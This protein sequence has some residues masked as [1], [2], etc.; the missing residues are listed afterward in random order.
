M[1]LSETGQ[2]YTRVRRRNREVTD[3]S[4]IRGFLR[5]APM[6][7]V[8]TVHEGQPFLNS[9]LFLYDEDAHVLYFHSA[10]EGRTRSNIEANGRV[11]VSIA[12]MGRMLT[13]EKVTDY[14]VEY[15]SVTVFG[16]ARVVADPEEVRSVLERQ[17][18]KYFPHRR[19]GVDYE[20]FT[21]LEA[22]RAA[23]YRIEIEQWSAKQH[24]EPA[25]FPSAFSY[26]EISE[27]A[28]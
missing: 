21:D 12:E 3:E 5:R 8:A 2:A 17:L 23:V 26:R 10:G 14:S 16:T 9:N 19:A 25:D 1:R 18:A 15:A 28:E 24:K 27:A 20:P 22:S 6:C 7:T 13:A 4:W 11:C